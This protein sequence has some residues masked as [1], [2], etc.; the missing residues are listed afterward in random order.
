MPTV[1][2]FM[3]LL[4]RVTTP[5]GH[6]PT[7]AGLRLVR[8]A[9]NLSA[10]SRVANPLAVRSSNP[11]P[12]GNRRYRRLA[13]CA[14]Q[15]RFMESDGGFVPSSASDFR[16]A[17]QHVM[18]TAQLKRGEVQF[19]RRLQF[20]VVPVERAHELFVVVTRLVPVRSAQT[21][22]TATT[23]RYSAATSVVPGVLA[24]LLAV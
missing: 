1:T 10:V 18:R 6:E 21:L 22:R 19:E 5:C 20:L 11:S 9:D 14:T 3:G 2:R 16:R 13:T 17:E 24:M 8:S 12:I 4:D 15:Q 23:S 7:L